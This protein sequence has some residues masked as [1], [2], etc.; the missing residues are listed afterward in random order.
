MEALLQD[1][2]YALRSL[3]G[4]PA[5]AAVAVLTLSVG[6]G[7]NAAVFTAIDAALLRSLPYAEPERLVHLWQSHPTVDHARFE[8]AWPT[9]REWQ[10]DRAV[11]SG[12]AGYNRALATWDNGGEL[13]QLRTLQVSSNFLQ[14]LGVRPLLGRELAP[15]E[16]DASAAPVALVTDG[17]WR[18]RLG[19]RP[20]ILGTTLRLDDEPVT[21]VG[22][23]P[24]DFSWAP[25]NDPQL[26]RAVQPKEGRLSRRNLYWIRPVAR[27]RDGVTLEQAQAWMGQVASTLEERFPGANRATSVL[28]TPLR[29]ELLGAVR[30]TLVLLF[31]CVGL[32]LLVACV[33]VANLLLA[34]A[35]TREREM[36]VRGALGAGRRRLVQQ[37]LT[38]SLVLSAVGGALG[39]V[40]A[41]I[42]LPLLRLGI[43]AEQRNTLPFLEHLVIDGRVLAYGL[44]LIILTALLFGLLPALRGSKADLHATLKEG[45]APGAGLRG[46][47]LRDGLVMLEV[48][49][50]VVLLGSAG[51]MGKS[52]NRILSVD[53]GFHPEGALGVEV[54]L[55]GGN[56]IDDARAIALTPQLVEAVG[57]VPGVHG[58][59]AVNRL[60]GRGGGGTL[61]F[62]RTDQPPPEGLQPEATYRDVDPSY[63]AILGLPLLGG[64]SFERGDVATTTPVALVNRTLQRRFFPNEDP[65]G[66]QIKLTYRPDAPTLTIVGVVGD[67]QIDSLDAP[68]RSILYRSMTQDAVGALGLVVRTART[69]AGADIRRALLS[70]S[71]GLTV[72]P[73]RSLSSIFDQAPQMFVRRFPAFVL[74]VFAA[75]ALLLA[76]VGIFG[77]VSYA[78]EERTHEF[79]IRLA[80]GADREDIVKLVLRRTLPALLG[81]MAAGLLG[82]VALAMVFRGL[83]FG[84][85]VFDPAVLGSVAGVLLAVGILAA[86]LPARRAGKVDPMQSMRAI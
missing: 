14:L 19:G 77:V 43:P 57:A 22:V 61:R 11:F 59:A 66:K 45:A 25:G 6:I 16:D 8:A 10:E 82:A 72:L 56:A 29:E 30:P 47:S 23:L 17:F 58:A 37:L 50:A 42:T 35:T 60:P 4:R 70:V 74:M 3:R 36:A 26:L 48:A 18:N 2:R 86:W 49:L 7:L 38:E 31:A 28:V 67:E 71:P 83:L 75:S 32:V 63:F 15:G 81:G 84:V 79:G 51:L 52:L 41:R 55:P 34:R 33:N 80:V 20:D 85:E 54:V 5:F 62:L 78:V 24:A 68:T 44:T 69:D 65:V 9:F 39:I 64:R 21:I 27:L 73:I 1:L 46:Q 76:C 12:V 40:V 53:P 13:E